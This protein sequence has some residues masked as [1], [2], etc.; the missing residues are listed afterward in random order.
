MADSALYIDFS[1]GTGSLGNTWNAGASG[2]QVTLSNASGI[3]EW[4]SGA[5]SG[6]GYGVYDI[7]AKIDG[8]QPGPAILFW[9]GDNQWPGQEIDLVEVAPD[10]SGRQYGTLHWNE[11]G[12]DAYNAQVYEGVSSG[13]YHDYQMIW[14]A[15]KITMSI[16]GQV[17]AVFTDHVPADFDHGG[18]NNTIGALNLNANTSIAI[19]SVSYH[20]FG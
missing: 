13:V 15:G 18:M 19:D 7:V 14:E 20:P 8:S 10:G 17:K 6:H 4:A 1:N 16:D 11:N 2:G 12:H 9:P 5:A 3:M